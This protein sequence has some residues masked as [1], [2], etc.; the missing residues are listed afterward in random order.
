MSLG[1]DNPRKVT[2]TS[3]W[4]SGPKKSKANKGPRHTPKKR[5]KK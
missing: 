3:R 1:T 4:K 5:R 2:F